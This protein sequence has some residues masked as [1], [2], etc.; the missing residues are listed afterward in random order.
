MP[1]RLDPFVDVLLREGGDQLYLLP[2]EPVTM[3]KD[4]KPRK[5]SRQPLTDQHIYSLLVE[6]APSESADH[7]DKMAETEFEYVADRGL[8]KVRVVPDMGRLTAVV[9]PLDHASVVVST[10]ASALAAPAPTPAPPSPAAAAAPPKPPRPSAIAAAP[11]VDAAAPPRAGGPTAPPALPADF[12]APQYKAAERALGD[13][14]KALVASSSSDLHLRVGEPP[15]FRTHGEVKRQ[16]TPP[17]P[18]EQ[19]EMMVLAV[20]PERNRAEWKETGDSDFAY[21]IP[22][23]A[24][25]RVNVG[26]DRKGP[27]AVFRV[28]PAQVVTVEQL[29]IAKEVQ[30]LCYLTKGLVLITGPTGSGKSTTLCALV[31][32]INRTR[33]DHIITIEDPI[34]FVHEPK[35][36]VVTQREVGV[37]TADFKSALRAA[38]R[39]D[40]DIVLVGEM[41]DLETIAIAIETAETG[42]LVFGTLH[43]TT[44]AST[45]DRIID[46]FP[47]DRQAQ[48]RVMLSESLKGVISQT[49]CKRLRGGRVAAREILL[50]T[51]AI[52]NLIREGKTFQVPSIIQTSKQLGMVTLNDALLDLIEKQ[53]ISPDEAYMKSV[54]RAALAATLKAKGHKLSLT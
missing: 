39:E 31:D 36:C 50:S 13:L 44:A 20:M 2:D 6:V 8:V 29:G 24:R 11:M 34:E 16:G 35:K 45:V 7:I 26:R 5:V 17:V 38:L 28:I 51:P 4:G 37:H 3:V 19:L 25:F 15:V 12:A 10:T 53:E 54:E 33:T 48:I 32:L 46:Q 47:A 9:A 30:Q 27:L 41:R 1:A 40:P 43:T 22:G 23:L 42:H 52:A 18:A 21:E 49:L 14:L